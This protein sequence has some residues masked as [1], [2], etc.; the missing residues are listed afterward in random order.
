M[1]SPSR[2][3]D[4]VKLRIAMVAPPWISVPPLGYGGV[5]AAVFSLVRGLVGLGHRVELFTVG[6]SV[7]EGA[8]THAIFDSGQYNR[9]FDPLYESAAIPLAHLLAARRRI[10]ELG[11]M[12]LVHDHNYLLGPTVFSQ[13]GADLPP[14]LHT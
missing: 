11:S 6:E 7:V 9:I 8:E 1:Q 13:P 2:G 10:R 14:V 3:S 12:D 4:T 5:E